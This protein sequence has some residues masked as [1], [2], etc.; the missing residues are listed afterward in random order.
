MKNRL[1]YFL[2]AASLAARAAL[3]APEVADDKWGTATNDFQISIALKDDGNVIRT[4]KPVKLTLWI[5]NVSTNQK[6]D[7]L[8]PN[9]AR[10]G[11]DVV[12]IEPSGKKLATDDPQEGA[13]SAQR[14]VLGP[15]QVRKIE[16]DLSKVCKFDNTGTYQITAMYRMLGLISNQ[17]NVSVLPAP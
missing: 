4:N 5:K 8:K 15:N 10:Q 7:I 2:I 17:L 16:I 3:A 13:V 6:H 1:R 11:F 14:F 12:V 9:S